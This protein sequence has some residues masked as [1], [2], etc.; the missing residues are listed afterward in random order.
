VFA[1]EPE[2]ARPGAD[3]TG[4]GVTRRELIA[5]LIGLGMLAAGAFF[6]RRILFPQ[7]PEG[8][9]LRPLEAFSGSS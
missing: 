8:E 2:L 3:G 1:D 5:R 7:R 4:P 6:L 9:S